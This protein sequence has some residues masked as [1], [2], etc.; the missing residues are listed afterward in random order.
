MHEK[1]IAVAQTSA[2]IRL[3]IN[4]AKTKMLRANTPSNAM[5][6]ME[7]KEIEVVENFTYLVV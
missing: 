4:I 1:I 6:N 3:N 2:Q 5:L 7:G